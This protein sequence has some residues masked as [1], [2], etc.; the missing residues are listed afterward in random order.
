MGRSGELDDDA[1]RGLGDRGGQ[2]VNES[3]Q[4]VTLT[5][6]RLTETLPLPI[7]TGPPA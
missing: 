5:T 1:L 4:S 6:P 3:G 7:P 2:G